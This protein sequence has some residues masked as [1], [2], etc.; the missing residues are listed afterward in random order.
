[1]SWVI[2]GGESG[3]K[4]R[5]IEY[6]WID[7]IRIMSKASNVPFFFKQWGKTKFN[8]NPQDPTIDKNH[9]QHAKGGCELSGNIYR[10]M[11][12]IIA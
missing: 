2:V 11:P 6:S 9:P 10:E 12:R 4:A 3:H 1:M 7:K 8:I 5:P